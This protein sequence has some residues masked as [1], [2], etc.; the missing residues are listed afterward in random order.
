MMSHPDRILS[1]TELSE[2]VYEEERI[3]DSNVIEVYI[4]RLR[5]RFGRDFIE[6]RRGQGYRLGKRAQ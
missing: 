2:H 3:T 4:N 6:T 5:R 1:K